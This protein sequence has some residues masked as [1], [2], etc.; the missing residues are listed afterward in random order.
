MVREEKFYGEEKDKKKIAEI[1]LKKNSLQ[2]WKVA[3]EENSIFHEKS[4]G[5]EACKLQMLLE[6]AIALSWGLRK[7][8]LGINCYRI[9]ERN[10]RKGDLTIF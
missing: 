4:V 10:L 7:K 9:T 8:K 5:L 2:T 1:K 3:W 6:I